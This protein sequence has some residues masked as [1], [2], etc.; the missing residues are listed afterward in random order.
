M[1]SLICSTKET[2]EVQDTTYSSNSVV[3]LNIPD[4]NDKDDT[5]STTSPLYKKRRRLNKISQ[6]EVRKFKVEDEKERRKQIIQRFTLL[7]EQLPP[8]SYK[9]SNAELLKKVLKNKEE[10]NLQDK[11]LQLNLICTKLNSELEYFKM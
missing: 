6:G 9:M 10:K 7:K 5:S 2:H 4:S 11:W 8:T 1:N 3:Q